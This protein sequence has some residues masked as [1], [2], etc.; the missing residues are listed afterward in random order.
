VLSIN[1]LYQ[2]HE[3]FQ[4]RL[5]SIITK[6][7]QVGTFMTYGS[8][9][10][11][12]PP[13]ATVTNNLPG[14]NEMIRTGQPL[15]LKDL[16]CHCYDPT[17][18]QVLNPAAWTNPVAGTYGP[19]P[20]AVIGT[21]LLYTDFRGPRRPSE[22]FN[23]LRSFRLAKDKPVVLSIRADFTNILNRTILPNPGT[24]NPAGAPTKNNAGQL[25]AGFGVIPE[26]FAVG[27]FPASSNANASQLPRQG[28][29][30]ARITF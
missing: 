19:G 23:I 14:G 17:H 12:T 21:N 9:L 7:W 22:S 16:N 1:I 13:A 25:T 2:T 30:V 28:T 6:D 24:S 15:Y 27:A 4:N 3:Y 29:I 18:E 20:S 8:G 11:L 10:P 5:A 26:V